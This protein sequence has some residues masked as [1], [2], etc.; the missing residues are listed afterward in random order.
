VD[1][2][3]KALLRRLGRWYGEQ[4]FAIAWTTT[5]RPDRGDPKKV[6][7]KGWQHTQPLADGDHGEAMF[8][9]GLT[10]NPAIVLR[11]S[12]LIGVECDGEEDL[13][14]VEA[15][16]LPATLTERS[17]LPTKQH[18]YF[19][20]PAELEVVTKVS[21]R[22]ESG[23]VTAAESNYYVCAPAVHPSGETYAHLPGLG[24]GEVEIA[25]FPAKVYGRL[26]AD[27]AAEQ[28]V[29]KQ[30]LAGA[31]NGKVSVG[32]RHDVVFQFACAM[33]RWM[34]S[35]EELL[36][37]ALAYNERHCDPPMEEKRVLLQVRGALK[38]GE[39]PPDPDQLE[40]RRQADKLLREFLTGEIKPPT[41]KPANAKPSKRRRELRR[42]AGSSIEARPVEWLVPNVV[43]LDTLTLIAGVG[44]LGKSMLALAWAAEISQEGSDFLVISY[45]DA[46]EQI[47]RPRFEALGGDLDRLHELSIDPADGTIS[48][49]VDLGEIVRHA[50]DTEA[51]LILIDP[52]SASIDI[53]LDAH[54]DAHVRVVLGQLAKLAEQ[55]HLAVV[56]IA[57]LNKAPGADPYLRINGSTAFYN[58]S[59]SVLTVTRDP[60]EDAHR[61]VA[62]HKSNYGML[63]PVERWRLETVEV[64]S[65]FGPLVVARLVFLEVADDVDRDDVLAPPPVAEKRGEAEALIMVELAQGRRLSSEVKAVGIR[66]GIS[67]STI[68]R[69]ARGLEVVVEEETTQSGRVTLWSLPD[70]LGGR[71]TPPSSQ[72]DATRQKSPNQAESEDRFR[73]SPHEAEEGVD[74][75]P[76]G[77]ERQK[78]DEAA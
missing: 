76:D 56:M 27:A 62:H 25:T 34:R 46:A 12:G 53:K 44:G 8:G 75:T 36:A 29:R 48:F 5:N 26:I 61:L 9:R 68:E 71:V 28:R 21:F 3:R 43:P 47:I 40:L 20:L 72:D 30:I 7:T 65:A 23:N 42:R 14:R 74:A 50:T 51:K 59:R 24:P 77:I 11:P 52:V 38:M 10:C 73:G 18:R 45:E 54:K 19:R 41:T 60:D 6:T 64:P 13:A 33:R 16:G 57:H 4:R 37:A 78:G 35:E 1:D 66:Q 55:L 67:K 70:W 22:F 2:D 31:S 58:A 49:P 15:L 39:R 69:A 17:S 32:Q 63:A